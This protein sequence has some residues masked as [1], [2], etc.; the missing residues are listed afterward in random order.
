MNELASRVAKAAAAGAALLTFVLAA[1]AGA[2]LEQLLLRAGIAFVL[3]WAA[4]EF[5]VRRALRTVLRRV[6]ED[7]KDRQIDL[8]VH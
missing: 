4:G 1:A 3:T 5:L 6:L 2:G 7:R 8:T